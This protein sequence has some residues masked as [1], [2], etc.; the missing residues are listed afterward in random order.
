M[1]VRWREWALE[2]TPA[3]GEDDHR[4]GPQTL[5]AQAGKGRRPH[6]WGS[7]HPALPPSALASPQGPS[8]S[9]VQGPWVAGGPEALCL[10]LSTL[11]YWVLMPPPLSIS[12]GGRPRLGEQS[13]DPPLSPGCP[14]G[15]YGKHCRKKCHCANWG[16]CHRLYGACLCD[17]GL[18]GRFCHLGESH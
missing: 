3:C 10:Y 6:S 13:R 15:F 9:R 17:P 5:G 2:V 7:P 12:L 11:L 1:L 4:P 8:L 16:R 18:Y 14:K